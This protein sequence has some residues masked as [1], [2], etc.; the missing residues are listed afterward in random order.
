[1]TDKNVRMQY[2]GRRNPFRDPLYGTGDWEQGQIKLLSPDIAARCKK[3]IDTWAEDNPDPEAAEAERK[4]TEAK[5]QADAARF[6]FPPKTEQAQQQPIAVDTEGKVIEPEAKT[7]A[8]VDAPKEDAPKD[9]A[10]KDD[11]KVEQKLEVVEPPPEKTREEKLA[12]ERK[13]EE[14]IAAEKIS[15][16]AL[17]KD[18]LIEYAAVHYGQKLDAGKTKDVLQEE[19]YGLMDRFGLL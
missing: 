4:A 13:A 14:A 16:K 9:E 8:K 18:K 17:N 12:E 11:A 1:M 15:V 7:D 10:P 2:I 3:H 19:V 6:G 5:R